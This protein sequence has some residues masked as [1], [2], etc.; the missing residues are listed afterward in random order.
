MRGVNVDLGL[1]MRKD[2][3]SVGG[4]NNGR[5]QDHCRFLFG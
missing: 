3:F 1:G 2:I 5:V 4:K